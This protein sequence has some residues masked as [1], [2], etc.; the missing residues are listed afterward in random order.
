MA[1]R[2]VQGAIF[3]ML[4]GITGSN[5]LAIKIGLRGAPPFL[6]ASLQFVIASFMFLLLAA[7]F[8]ARPPRTRIEWALVAFVG[9]V[10]FTAEYGLIFWGEANGVESGLA[11]ILFA[12]L[13][14]QTAVVAHR[15]LRGE[16]L[17]IQKTAG[18]VLGF[19]GLLVVFRG[20]L[21]TAGLGSFLPMAALVVAATCGA[22]AT[23]AMKRWGQGANL[24]SFNAVAMGTGALALAGVSLVAGERWVCRPGPRAWGRSCISASSGP[25][26]PSWRSSGF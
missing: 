14:L 13:P 11:A 24:F 12:T 16:K 19:G 3:A 25:G 15:F 5:F 7:G 2:I 23:V 6:A 18:I 21:E 20:Q 1:S 22:A 8:K 9:L 17:T 10:I 4:C 26:W